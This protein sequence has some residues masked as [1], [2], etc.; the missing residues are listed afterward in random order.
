MMRGRSPITNHLRRCSG[1]L[2]VIATKHPFGD[3]GYARFKWTTAE[4]ERFLTDGRPPV[5]MDDL[6]P[7]SCIIPI[8]YYSRYVESSYN[9]PNVTAAQFRR[10]N[11]CNAHRL[12]VWDMAGFDTMDRHMIPALIPSEDVRPTE[13]QRQRFARNAGLQNS[14]LTANITGLLHTGRYASEYALGNGGPAVWD[15]AD[16][17]EV[18]ALLD[19]FLGVEPVEHPTGIFRNP[20]EYRHTVRAMNTRLS[21][22][23]ALLQVDLSLRPHLR[24]PTSIHS[25]FEEEE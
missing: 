10:I 3:F 4:K 18:W 11:S 7:D 1:S 22:E 16:W 24:L 14:Q 2:V 6:P 17:G 9:G 13:A 21:E 5:T 15:G 23:Q 25:E 12:L 19:S 20:A 8:S